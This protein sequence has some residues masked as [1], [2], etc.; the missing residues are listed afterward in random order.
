MNDNSTTALDAEENLQEALEEIQEGLKDLDR[1]K[2]ASTS[3]DQAS[4][5]SVEILSGLLDASKLLVKAS[6]NLSDKGLSDFEEK[7]VTM[8]TTIKS[9]S[10]Q[11]ER[12]NSGMNDQL[13]SI[14]ILV[15]I[16]FVGL[17]V[18]M[19]YGIY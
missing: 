4:Q 15:L 18:I 13:K 17:A 6:A 16:G 19:G 14:K 3:L 2:K 10:S 7:L 11:V 9:L 1:F 8:A 12:L 5:K